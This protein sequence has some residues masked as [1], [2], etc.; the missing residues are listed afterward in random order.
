MKKILLTSILIS[1]ILSGYFIYQEYRKSIEIQSYSAIV[2]ERAFLYSLLTLDKKKNTNHLDAYIKSLIKFD[3]R[4]MSK[5]NHIKNKINLKR[6][7]SNLQNIQSDANDSNQSIKNI[8][9]EVCPKFLL[10]PQL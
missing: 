9:Y 5:Y 2:E 6:Y 3:L 7:C 4:V 1:I 10:V 8:F